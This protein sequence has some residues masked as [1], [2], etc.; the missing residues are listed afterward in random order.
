MKLSAAGGTKPFE[1]ANGLAS[2]M[3]DVALG[4]KTEIVK[5]GGL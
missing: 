2:V 5:Y 3:S 4:K 1:A